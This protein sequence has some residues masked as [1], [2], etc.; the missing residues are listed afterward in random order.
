MLST[1]TEL[2]ISKC[3]ETARSSTR[4]QSYP[5]SRAF[6]ASLAKAPSEID[7]NQLSRTKSRSSEE[8]RRLVKMHRAAR[9][10]SQERMA[11]EAEMDHSLVSRL[12]SGQR[13]A[14]REAI[15]KLACGLGLLPA[16]KDR[17]LIAAGFFPDNPENAVADEP[18][19][20]RLYR[21]LRDKTLPEEKRTALRALLDNI[22]AIFMEV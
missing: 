1:L 7:A 10:W 14:T 9:N 2:P 21:L 6:A 5:V 3:A 8:F 20:T 15:N 19:I 13:Y 4:R 12:E 22:T 17:L 16:D 11:A 18:S